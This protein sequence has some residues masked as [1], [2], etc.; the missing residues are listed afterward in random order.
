MARFALA[1]AAILILTLSAGLTHGRPQ[2]MP[3]STRAASATVSYENTN[4]FRAELLLIKG[5][6]IPSLTQRSA[7][8]EPPAPALL[9]YLALILIGSAVSVVLAHRRLHRE[10]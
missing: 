7:G 5:E 3:L 10:M 9:I 8:E 6:A 4:A 1:L 2:G